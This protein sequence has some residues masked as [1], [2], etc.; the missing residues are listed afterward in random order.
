M[1]APAGSLSPR[2]G[3]S[4]GSSFPQDA[5]P[6]AGQ[7][8]ALFS[9]AHVQEDPGP[10]T[11]QEDRAALKSHEDQVPEGGRLPGEVS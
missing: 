7:Q 4:D 3:G 5:H 8:L 2:Q 9:E 10:A 6:Q 1:A 11:E